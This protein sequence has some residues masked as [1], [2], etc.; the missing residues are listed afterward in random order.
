MKSKWTREIDYLKQS[1]LKDNKSYEQIG[2]EYNC[3]GANIRKVAIRLGIDIPKRRVINKNETFN[4]GKC[5]KTNKI[6][7]NCKE[8]FYP[9]YTNNKYCCSICQQKYQSKKRYELL[10]KGDLSIMRANY[11][12]KFAKA[13]ILEEQNNKCAICGM[14]TEW[15]N[16]PIVFILDHI[17]GYASNNK[18][19]NLRC[20]CPNCDSQLDTYKSKNKNGERYY[21][22]YKNK[23][24]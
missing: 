24:N 3:S 18:R 15:N 12:P 23:I 2:K 14:N 19:N 9:Y 5:T 10:L 20:I 1:I 6:C 8:E 22:R 11:I 13:I 16:K 7:L 4:K 21:Y 17:D